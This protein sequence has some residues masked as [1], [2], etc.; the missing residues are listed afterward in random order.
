MMPNM[1]GKLPIDSY[2]NKTNIVSGIKVSQPFKVMVEKKG[3]NYKI[4]VNI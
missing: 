3:Y 1:K 2:T 4:K